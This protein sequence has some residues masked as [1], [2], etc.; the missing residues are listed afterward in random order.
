MVWIFLH[1]FQA[2]KRRPF[3]RFY[4][5]MG[6]L[7]TLE[8]VSGDSH[9]AG[10]SKMYWHI[11]VGG[12]RVEIQAA[13]VWPIFFKVSSDF[14]PL[15]GSWVSWGGPGSQGDPQA[16]C[17]WCVMSL[18]FEISQIRQV[19]PKLFIKTPFEQTKYIFINN[20]TST[21]SIWAS[22]VSNTIY[23]SRG[24][25]QRT[26]RDPPGANSQWKQLLI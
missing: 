3:L 23:S 24:R 21:A 12:L 1:F 2:K 4:E 17:P 11:S 8:L 15:K 25:C 6:G 13:K 19:F 10:I 5:A 9:W 7:R 18:G 16:H 20:S 14:Q 26:V 22:R